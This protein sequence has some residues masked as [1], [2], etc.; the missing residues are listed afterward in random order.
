MAWEFFSRLTV[1]M[2]LSNHF[3]K[4]SYIP[5]GTFKKNV[6]HPLKINYSVREKKMSFLPA[7]KTE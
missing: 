5:N 6:L 7:A 3:N 1:S 2:P 4:Y